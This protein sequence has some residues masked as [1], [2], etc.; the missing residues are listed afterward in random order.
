MNRED[1]L[2]LEYF[3]GFVS[4]SRKELMDQVLSDR[5]RQVT[6][7]LEDIYQSQNASAVVRTCDCFGIQDLYIIENRHEYNLNPRVVHGASKWINMYRFNTSENNT[8]ECLTL[9]KQKGYTIVG[10]TPD[11]T[12]MSIY[13]LDP[14]VKPAI[15]FGTEALGLSETA[16]DLC[17]QMVT[18][19]MYGFTE[20]LNISVS[21]SLCLSAVIPALR[22]SSDSWQLTDAEK[23]ELRLSWYRQSVNRYD[24]LER[25]FLKKL[26]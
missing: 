9:L 18:Y 25:E 16:I 21:V 24:I 3:S 14:E 4:E 26:K 17:D 6:V 2:L 15:L 13:D 23:D 7:V 8:S 1:R 5:T 19:P 22:N 11:K 20:S 10:T 12:A